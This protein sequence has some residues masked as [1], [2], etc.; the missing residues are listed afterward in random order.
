MWEICTAVV[1]SLEPLKLSEPLK[2]YLEEGWEPFCVQYAGPKGRV[3]LRRRL[4][5][6]HLKPP[7]GEIHE[8]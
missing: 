1:L 2:E 7:P 5:K 4:P 6:V 3:W 8:T